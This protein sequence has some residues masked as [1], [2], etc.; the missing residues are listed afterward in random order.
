MEPITIKTGGQRPR[1]PPI[2]CWGSKGDNM[3]IYCPHRGEKVRNVHNV[4]QAEIV[5]DMGINVPRIYA[6]LE[7][8][9]A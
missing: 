5:E 4:Q 2:H 9:Q 8:K 3:F 7:N 1:Q 6:S